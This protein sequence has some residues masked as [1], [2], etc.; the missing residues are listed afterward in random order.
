MIV[1]ADAGP[2]HYLVLI[3]A[4]DVL[5]PLYGRVLVPQTVAGELQET[6]TPAAVRAWIEQPP[7][8]FEI[9]PDP[10]S[11]EALRFLDPGERAAIA[12]ALSVDAK[13]I[14]IDEQAGRISTCRR[15]WSIAFA[16]G[17]PPEKENRDN[18]TR[19]AADLGRHPMEG[20]VGEPGSIQ[21]F[22]HS[23]TGRMCRPRLLTGNIS[24]Q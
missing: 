7:E 8:W 17:C 20:S 1:V 22:G 11:E 9:R 12:L 6:N 13:R 2:L 5:Q 14:L 3:G 10:P 24:T 16:G 19:A 4:M 21:A 15:N 23:T 18:R